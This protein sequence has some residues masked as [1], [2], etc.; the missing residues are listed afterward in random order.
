[1]RAAPKPPLHPRK[2]N[3]SHPLF[4]ELLSSLTRID[5]RSM[6]SG[7]RRVVFRV[8]CSSMFLMGSLGSTVYAEKAER[9]I[10][11]EDFEGGADWQES[12]ELEGLGEVEIVDGYLRM[13]SKYQHVWQEAYDDGELDEDRIREDTLASGGVSANGI[14]NRVSQRV[15]LLA[16]E[17]GYE[18]DTYRGAHVVLWNK[19]VVLPKNY[20]LVYTFK[21]LSPI[22]LHVL[23]L[24]A[25]G[26]NGED[27]FDEALGT[28]HGRYA[29]YIAGDI[30]NYGISLFANNP[31]FEPFRG[32]CNLRKNFGGES[33]VVQTGVD[34]VTVG[35]AGYGKS[36]ENFNTH[37]IEV[38]KDGPLFVFK[39]DGVES[40]SWID[41]KEVMT[42]KASQ[43]D[44]AQDTVKDTGEVLYGGR[45][46][47]RQMVHLHAQ[48]DS[49]RVYELVEEEA[50]NLS[51][52]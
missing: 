12:W 26:V 37:T 13:R 16:E 40:F 42:L 51:I 15:R 25:Q 47:L 1:M 44:Y 4:Y 19:A 2:M 50:C 28:R 49:F 48:Y 9:L 21:A 10:Y 31:T 36:P 3:Y 30:R 32:T 27:I 17:D 45:I 22:G 7:L 6:S 18:W 35:E 33:A 39:V 24:N 8:V 52:E 43:F 14:R 34:F 38:L 41:E 29:Q 23:F 46:G 20:R 5:A 11:Q